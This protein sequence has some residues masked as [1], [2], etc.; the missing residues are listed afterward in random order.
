MFNDFV[1][2]GPADDPAGISG[3]ESAADAF[4]TVADAGATFVS[5]GDDSGTNK[6]ELLIWEAAGV[7]PSGTWYR[8]IGK[9][10]GD[11]LVQADQSGAYTLSDR[12]TFISQR[13]EID[14]V[15]LVQGP[16]EDGRVPREPVRSPAGHRRRDGVTVT[17]G[18]GDIGRVLPAPE[19]RTQFRTI[20]STANS[21]SSRKPCPR[22]PT[23]SST[24]QKDGVATQASKRVPR[25]S[26]IPTDDRRRPSVPG[27]VRVEYHLRL[28]IR[29]CHSRDTEHAVQPPDRRGDGV[30]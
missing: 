29:E 13:S 14:L 18:R 12:G 3:M 6:K 15:I 25:F 5:R 7:E 28:T 8:E 11:T 4:A 1:V 16:I 22:T 26:R 9:G 27:R 23:S 10:M 24:C 21:C 20:R 17:T 19:P 2:V 30:F